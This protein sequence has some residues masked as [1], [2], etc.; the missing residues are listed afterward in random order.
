MWQGA[1]CLTMGCGG[2]HSECW[3][4][5]VEV[6]GH[7]DNDHAQEAEITQHIWGVPCIQPWC[8]RQGLG[9]WCGPVFSFS[10]SSVA[11]SKH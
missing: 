2:H 11:T 3:V 1:G 5:R 7:M 4:W 10:K 9:L 8:A 6:G